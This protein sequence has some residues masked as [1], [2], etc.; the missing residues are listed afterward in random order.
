MRPRVSVLGV[1]EP[2]RLTLPDSTYVP[3]RGFSDLIAGSAQGL[4]R[5][6]S[7]RYSSAIPPVRWEPRA[8]AACRGAELRLGQVHPNFLADVDEC[9]PNLGVK[10]LHIEEKQLRQ[11][12]L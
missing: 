10:I 8:A 12:M 1:D 2:A 3:S 6:S 4:P 7:R 9:R 11:S 5:I